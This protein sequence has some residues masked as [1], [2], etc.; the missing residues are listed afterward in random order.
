MDLAAQAQPQVLQPLPQAPSILLQHQPQSLC[1]PQ[2]SWLL[3]AGCWCSLL[4]SK[5]FGDGN[6]LLQPSFSTRAQ[7]TSCRAPPHPQL[8]TQGKEL[9]I[10]PQECT[11]CSSPAPSCDA[12]QVEQHHQFVQGAWSQHLDLGVSLQGNT[13][14]SGVPPDKPP[15]QLQESPLLPQGHLMQ[16]VFLLAMLDVRSC[17]ARGFPSKDY[18]EG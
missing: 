11:A 9:C 7:Q 12:H 10:K 2:P 6:K 18:K 15:P 17:Q 5:W 16:L 13:S 14:E 3:G 4:Y 8:L 1:T